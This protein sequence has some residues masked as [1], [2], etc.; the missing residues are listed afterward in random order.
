MLLIIIV[1]VVVV[2]FSRSPGSILTIG[3]A[4]LVWARLERDIHNDHYHHHHHHHRRRRR[5]I[6]TTHSQQRKL[7]WRNSPET[8]SF[9]GKMTRIE[10]CTSFFFCA[11][12]SSSD[13]M[14]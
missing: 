8:Q 10:L 9:V 11:A 3:F 5:T 7:S 1:V 13:L 12:L 4:P 6:T 2:V 14:T